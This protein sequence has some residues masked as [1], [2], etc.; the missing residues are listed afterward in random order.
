MKS[1]KCEREVVEREMREGRM[2][3]VMEERVKGKKER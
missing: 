3:A 1:L 2:K